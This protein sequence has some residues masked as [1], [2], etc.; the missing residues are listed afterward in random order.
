MKMDRRL[1]NG[2]AWAGALLVIGIP[3]ADFLTGALSDP[4]APSVA[5]VD[6]TPDA[7]ASAPEQIEAKPQTAVVAPIPATRP[8]PAEAPAPVAETKPAEPV[9]VSKPVEVASAAGNP[10]DAFV[11]SGKPLPSYINDTGSTP[12]AVA[13]AKP[14]TLAP[15]ANS[16]PVASTPAATTAP[17][18]PATAP[19]VEQVAALPPAQ[20]A[21][22][23]MPLS[24][25][26]KPVSVPLVSAPANPPLIID[27]PNGVTPSPVT[28]VQQQQQPFVTA[29]DL[30]DWESGPLSDFL[31]QRNG[32]SSASYQVYQ[33]QPA[34]PSQ[35]A[36]QDDGVWF[37]EAPQAD[38]PIR[39]FPS[40]DEQVYFS[41]F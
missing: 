35:P 12:Q 29:D 25:R 1:S 17:A 3:A 10:V 33:N 36:Y 38:R 28:P 11:Q 37:D 6:A 2:L 32:Q 18:A 9:K 22:V 7:V 41:P 21:P 24:M 20:V 34:Y 30:Q 39:R 13:P 27:Q 8:A 16:Q 5:V 23:P 4:G 14:V 15:T 19:A 26:P 40:N 31:A